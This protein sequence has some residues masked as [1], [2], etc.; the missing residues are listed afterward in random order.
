MRGVPIGRVAPVRLLQRH[1]QRNLV[2][3][4]GQQVHVIG[5]QAVA[6]KRQLLELDIL[7]QQLQV[8]GALCVGVQNDLSGVATRCEVVGNIYGYDTC[9]AR[10]NNKISENVPSVP[11]FRPRFPPECGGLVGPFVGRPEVNRSDF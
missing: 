7:L 3:R 5:H 4:D 10:H 11:N 2:V 9:Q 8:D 6:Q 1:G